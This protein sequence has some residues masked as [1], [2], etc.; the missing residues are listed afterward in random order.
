MRESGPVSIGMSSGPSGL[1]AGG[2]ECGALV[3]A[4]DWGR[5]PLGPMERW[6]A[7]LQTAAQICLE[8]RYGMCVFWGTRP[9]EFVAI[10]NDAYVPML[11]AKHPAALG[12]RLQDIWPEIWELLAP[13]L[14]AVVESGEP[15]WH[16]DQPLCLERNGFLEEAYFTYSFSPIRDESGAVAGIF[17][18]VHE[19][20]EQVLGTR[21]L[22]ALADLGD[23]M[24]ATS[25]E[26]E[27]VTAAVDAL[28][29]AEQDVELAA[30]YLI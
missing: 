5:S 6:P 25:T 22:Q 7:A 28:A 14:D 1:G 24:S 2:G 20:T 30:L 27:A 4:H 19:T 17:T 21:R 18:A 15:T 11:G 29:R 13:M 12:I 10:Y 9:P 8:S 26:A 3:R 16:E 23:R